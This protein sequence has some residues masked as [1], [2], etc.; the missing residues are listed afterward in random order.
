MVAD[1]GAR[2]VIGDAVDG[3]RCCVLPSLACA[4]PSGRRRAPRAQR[5]RPSLVV[6]GVAGEQG[7]IDWDDLASR[8]TGTV[9]TPADAERL[10]VL[11]YTSG[12]SR[13]PARRDAQPPCAAGQH[14]AGGG[15]RAAPVMTATTSSSGC[16]RCSTST[17]STPC[18]VRCSPGA[19]GSCW[20]RASTPTRRCGS[21]P[22]T[23]VTNLPVAPPVV[24]AW[25]G[26]PDLPARLRARTADRLRRRSARPGA[27][28]ALVTDAHR[29]SRSSRATG[30]PRPPRSCRRRWPPALLA[31]APRAADGVGVAVAGR[32]GE[33][34]RRRTATR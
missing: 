17:G 12:T 29:A 33:G 34:G 14:R 23:A 24:A 27:R 13:S 10:A 30:S 15:A 11:L 21:S 25:A 28:H 1:S 22:S 20:C 32:G 19:P 26:R 4:R 6:H 9:V 8:G 5:R 7:E 3:R 2:V 18:S 31:A 16:C